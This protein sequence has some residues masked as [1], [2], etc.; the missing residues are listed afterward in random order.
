MLHRCPGGDRADAGDDGR[1]SVDAIAFTS[2]STVTAWLG[3]AAVDALPP[4]V[5]CIGPVTAETAA[6]HRVPVTV[7]ATEHTVDGLVAALVATLRR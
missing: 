1:Q 6:E 2:S 3:V 4:V 5:A 7:V